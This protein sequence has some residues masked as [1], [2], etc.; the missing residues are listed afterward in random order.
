[1]QKRISQLLVLLVLASLIATPLSA[2]DAPAADTGA[3]ASFVYLPYIT[4]DA[5]PPQQTSPEVAA[6]PQP[7]DS[8]WGNNKHGRV[9]P[10]ERQAAAGRAAALGLRPSTV[11]GQVMAAAA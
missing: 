9:T 3:G 1:M 6:P 2:Q 5:Q 10:A 7:T 11:T 8:D 4:G